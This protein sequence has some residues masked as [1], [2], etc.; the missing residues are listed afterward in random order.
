[1]DIEGDKCVP[2]AFKTMLSQVWNQIVPIRLTLL[3]G[4]DGMVIQGTKVLKSHELR[5]RMHVVREGL[6]ARHVLVR[7]VK[8]DGNQR[9]PQWT[10]IERGDC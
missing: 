4:A 7:I 10:D 2:D 5:E 3:T 1:M 8:Y 9:E 6:P